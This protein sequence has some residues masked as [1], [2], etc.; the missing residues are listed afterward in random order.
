MMAK[1]IQADNFHVDVCDSC[2]AIHLALSKNSKNIAEV[3]LYDDTVRL[4][5]GQLQTLLE[6]KPHPCP[7]PKVGS[8]VTKQ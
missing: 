2:D 1:Y 7:A 3:V 4:L 8:G 5:I 6:S